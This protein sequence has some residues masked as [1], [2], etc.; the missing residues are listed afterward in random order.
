MATFQQQITADA[1]DTECQ[2]NTL[3]KTWTNKYA[4]AFARVGIPYKSKTYSLYTDALFRFL[5]DIPKGSTITNAYLTL[6]GYETRT[7]DFTAQINFLNSDDIPDF[8]TASPCTVADGGT[9]VAWVMPD[10]T[11]GVAVNT[12]NIASLIQ[13]FINRAGY[14]ANNHIA[15]RIKRGDAA[16]LEYHSF[17]QYYGS[18]SYA[19]ILTVEYTVPVAAKIAYTDGFV[20][21]LTA[22]LRR[23]PPKPQ[24]KCFPTPSFP[25]KCSGFRLQPRLRLKG[26]WQP[27]LLKDTQRKLC[28]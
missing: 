26:S 28:R 3:N 16:L 20:C 13:T 18:A 7:D 4:I 25:S 8:A 9:D 1:D 14:N 24:P 5:L 27:R 22:M 23:F 2:Y 10:I 21:V 6:V 15:I 12:P 11:A 19:A 17:Y